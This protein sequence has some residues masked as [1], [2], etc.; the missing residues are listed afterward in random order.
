MFSFFTAALAQE[1]EEEI[2]AVMREVSGE[3][4]AISPGLI[5]VIYNRDEDM[6][7]EDEIDLPIDKDVRLVHKSKLSDINI[8]DIV[9]VKYEELQKKEEIEKEGITETKTRIIGRKA[10]VITFVRPKREY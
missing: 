5:T 2:I 3:V 1:E 6:K 7:R 10:K 9:S 4:G 8:G